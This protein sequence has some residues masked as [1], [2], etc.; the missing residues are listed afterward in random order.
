MAKLKAVEQRSA[1]QAFWTLKIPAGTR[2]K[3]DV[4][5]VIMTHASFILKTGCLQDETGFNT[6]RVIEHCKP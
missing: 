2:T 4:F 1:K 6:L 5:G 3:V